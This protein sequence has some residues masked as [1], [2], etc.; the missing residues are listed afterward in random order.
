LSSVRSAR[1][2]M[3]CACPGTRSRPEPAGRTERCPGRCAAQ[4]RSGTGIAYSG[5]GVRQWFVPSE[6]S[7]A[8]RPPPDG[9]GADRGLTRSS[10]ERVTGRAV[11]ARRI[12]PS[13]S[14]CSFRPGRACRGRSR[15]SGAGSN[16]CGR[17][18]TSCPARR[19]AR[20]RERTGHLSE[21]PWRTCHAGETAGAPEGPHLPK[22]HSDPAVRWVCARRHRH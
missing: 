15:S 2:R 6:P 7:E 20:S 1:R 17:R 10:R 3:R 8:P 12:R 4:S 22:R 11:S 18:L 16:G 14:R 5:S 13:C 21:A 19:Q 9:S